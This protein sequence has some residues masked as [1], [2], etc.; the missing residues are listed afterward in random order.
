[1]R[2]LL[3]AAGLA[4]ASGRTIGMVRWVGSA[5]RAALRMSSDD[6]LMASLR[7]R[8]SNEGSGSSAPAPVGLDD[9]GA[10]V[11][12][13]QDVMAQANVSKQLTNWCNGKRTLFTTL[14]T[15]D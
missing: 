7:A 11:M 10:D 14:S 4:Y 12:G 8:M 1:M 9:V 3:L 15:V 6:D 2:G 5:P 13:P